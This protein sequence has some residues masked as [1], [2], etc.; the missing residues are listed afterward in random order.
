MNNNQ[1]PA[2]N[3]PANNPANAPAVPAPW[4]ATPPP[5][6]SVLQQGAQPPASPPPAPGVYAPPAYYSQP[7]G[8]YGAMPGTI[9]VAKP[10]QPFHTTKADAW[11]AVACFALGYLFIQWLLFSWQG[12]GVTIFTF[13]YAGTVLL[14]AKAKQI[15]PAKASWYWLMVLLFTGAA[16]SLWPSGSLGGWQG[17]LLFGAAVYWAASL[18]GG[19]LAGKSSN[20]LFLDGI[21]LLFAVPFKNFAC[22]FKGLKGFSAQRQP[23]EKDRRRVVLR[24]VFGVFL[25]AV[26]CIPLLAILLPMLLSADGGNFA[27]LTEGLAQLL[28]NFFNQLFDTAWLNPVFIVLAFPVGLYLCGLVAGLAHKRYTTGIDSKRAGKNIAGLRILP[29]STVVTVLTAVSLLYIVF[30]ASQAP[31]FFSAFAGKRPEGYEV[32]SQYAVSGFF[33]LCR[34]SI[35]NLGLLVALNTFCRIPR[36]QSRVLRLLNIALACLTLLVVCTA[37]SKM[38]LYIQAYGLSPRR[39]LTCVFMVFLAAVCIFTIV[40]QFKQ[41]SIVRLALVTGTAMLCLLGLINMDAVIVNYNAARYINGTLLE[42]DVSIVYSADVSGVQ[43]AL[44]VYQNTQD[45]NL[46][47]K[48]AEALQSIQQRAEYDPGHRQSLLSYQ[49]RGLS[50]PNLVE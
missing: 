23:E 41:F 33:E 31:Y 38:A 28:D 47:R 46:R 24:R 26:I 36:S 4:V 10:A 17:L 45:K 8:G 11:L 14:Y 3:T 6:A 25:G 18:F 29:T 43:G 30:I 44:A 49:V 42:F 19:L 40:L 48:I 1:P 39:V 35:I 16:Y 20:Y 32:Y 12:W 15:K 13:L 34:I 27:A 22:A 37:F 7:M 5:A 9:P 50:L 21:N 2:G